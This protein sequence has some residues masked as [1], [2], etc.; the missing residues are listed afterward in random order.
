MQRLAAEPQEQGQ[1]LETGGGGRNE[2]PRGVTEVG[3]QADTSPLPSPQ[4]PE[5]KAKQEGRTE[6][7][8]R[9]AAP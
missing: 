1:E 8:V 6:V 3:S 7:G 5:V 2:V 9:W 4:W